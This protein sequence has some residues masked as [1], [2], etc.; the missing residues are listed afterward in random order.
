MRSTSL[1][2]VVLICEWTA[3]E[4]VELLNRRQAPQ[5]IVTWLLLTL[6][7]VFLPLPLIRAPLELHS[8]RLSLRRGPLD[9]GWRSATKALPTTNHN[10]AVKARLGHLCSCAPRYFLG[11]HLHFEDARALC[12]M[13]ECTSNLP[14]SGT[15]LLQPSRTF[16]Q[17]PQH[18]PPPRS[19]SSMT[20]LMHLNRVALS[21]RETDSLLPCEH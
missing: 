4:G 10:L 19:S 1:Y 9:L 8:S 16:E 13:C 20:T 7:Q 12:V 5:P 14:H 15:C 2:G 6:F 11:T 17:F 3:K 18:L 21:R